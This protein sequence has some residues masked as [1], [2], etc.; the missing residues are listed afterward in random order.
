M[1]KKIAA[2][3]T[4]VVRNQVFHVSIDSPLVEGASKKLMRVASDIKAG[5]HPDWK[6]LDQRDV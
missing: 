1:K 4:R 2:T 5:I 3:G 6:V